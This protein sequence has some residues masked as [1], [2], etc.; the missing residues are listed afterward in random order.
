MAAAISVFLIVSCG[1]VNPLDPEVPGPKLTVRSNGGCIPE[2]IMTE[3]DS[4][5]TLL[6]TFSVQD[7]HCMIDLSSWG[8]DMADPAVVTEMEAD[9]PQGN[10]YWYAEASSRLQNLPSPSHAADGIITL[11]YQSFIEFDPPVRSIEFYY[12][13][14]VGNAWWGGEFVTGVDSMPVY[15]THRI[16][17]TTQYITYDQETLHANV[18][19]WQQLDTWTHVTLSAPYDAITVLW[20]DGALYIDDLKITRAIGGNRCPERPWFRDSNLLNQLRD[21]WEKSNPIEP[22]G[23]YH[24]SKEHGG[25]I[26]QDGDSYELVEWTNVVANECK[27][28]PPPFSSAPIETVGAVHTHPLAPGEYSAGACGTDPKIL[29]GGRVETGHGPSRA[30]PGGGGDIPWTQQ[31]G[32]PYYLIDKHGVTEIRPDGSYG[33]EH[34]GCVAG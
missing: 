17:G 27:I 15:A 29:N 6:V 7:T 2:V 32:K 24:N 22:G 25:W 28:D 33:P 14:P 4:T 23:D 30:G 11:P 34:E 16:P 26:V 13:T 31:F 8:I 20:F 5:E 12:S 18:A 19:S 10:M 21:L 1:E 3:Q 9:T